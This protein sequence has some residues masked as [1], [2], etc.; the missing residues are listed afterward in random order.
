[1]PIPQLSRN[2]NQRWRQTTH[3]SSK[4]GHWRENNNN[5][6]PLWRRWLRPIILLASS[7]FLLFA[8]Y[9]AY[10]TW[11]LPSP[12]KLMKR[13][14]AES[15]KIYARDCQTLL[16]EI[17]GEQ[18]RT[19]ITLNDIPANVKNA[20]IAIEDKNFYKHGGFSVVAIMRTAIT[21][22][23]FSKKAGGS[24]LTQ[25]FVKNAV[26]SNE[27]TY[28]RK[29]KE[30]LLSYRL[31][32]NFSKDQ[33]LQMYLNEIP[34]GSNAYGV[35]AASQFYFGKR[36]K[37]TNL[38]EAAILAALPQG[39]SRYSPY[40]AN[41]DLLITRQ[42]YILDLMVEQD[43]IS[44]EE[45]DA[46]KQTPIAFQK[47]IENITAPHFVMYIKEVLAEKYGEKTAEQ[48]G[49][50]VCT[51]LDAEK[52]KA[53]ETAVTAYG[54]RNAKQYN[55]SNA[56]LVSMDPKTGEVLAMVGSRDYFNEEIDGQV[57]VALKP[58]QPGSSFKPIA[59]TAAFI[60]GFYPET[61]V[62]D[63][64]TNFST[65][66]ANPYEPQN[67]SGQYYG[68]VS[69]RQA[70]AGSLNIPAVKA[71]YLAGL[72]NVISLA[73]TMGY[74]SLGDKNRYG[75]TLVLGGGEV[76]LLEHVNAYAALAREGELPTTIFIRKI[77]DAKGNVLEEFKTPTITKVIEPNFVRMT[78][79]ILSDNAA[80]AYVFG[81][82]NYLNLGA[83][84][85]AAKTGT[86]NDYRDAWTIGYTPSLVTGVW[87]GNNDNS[88]M[89]IGSDGSVVAA[90]IW[91]N[92][93]KA[94]L[95]NSP[96]ENFNT[97]TI[98][99]DTRGILL[100]QGFAEKII[101]IDSA[102]GLLATD[103]TPPEMVIEKTY[104]QTHNIL[105][106]V[107]K[108]N[109]N[110]NTPTNPENDPQFSSWENGV[111][112]WITSKQAKD[113]NFVVTQPP[114]ESDTE[115]KPE[116]KPLFSVFGL[117]QNQIITSEYLSVAL[118]ASAPRG[119]KLAEYYID[120]QLFSASNELP[121]ALTRSLKIL[122]NGDKKMTIKV[123]DDIYNCSSVDYTFTLNIP[124]T[125]QNYKFAISLATPADKSNFSEK[126]LPLAIKLNSLSPENIAIIKLYTLKDNQPVE[127]AT[128]KIV[129]SDIETLFWNFS[130]AFPAG[131]YTIWAEAT[132]W[133]NEKIVTKKIEINYLPSKVE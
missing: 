128:K 78:N 66:P 52:Q 111:A 47:R 85:V 94:A 61:S 42:K 122:P 55:A 97:Y 109:P 5:Q 96:I 107:D 64:P 115:H 46:A 37:D 88:K 59:Y 125:G 16:Y 72:D 84:P 104:A 21:N 129:R 56:A 110:N 1:M 45:A 30:L 62:Y 35:E 106:F 102:S 53:A 123:C 18:K 13:Q 133:N 114:T 57:N 83:R 50:N 74:T 86:T 90:P 73:K 60:K 116:N 12:D 19:L 89:K 130:P 48:G 2:N 79:S 121:F 81:A 49:F 15:T 58:R 117:T 27:K 7:F 132:G 10:L 69:F 131:T 63:A 28:T 51:T 98:A 100:G 4:S 40:G 77:K 71:L 6:Q 126:D 31:E 127:I 92:Y 17:H 91:N 14:V 80:R 9:I 36:A 33:I 3:H 38:A 11:T 24:T 93:M 113:H 70:L 43:Y 20:T 22:L 67:Y 44:Q 29:I 65:D 120:G 87:V 119:V 25:Q 41:K 68:P 108:D 76:T 118:T 95:G 82:Q 34:Y 105:Y 124:N 39:P 26:L 101:K 103:N 99:P 54:D 32:Q 8:I 75:L 112:K 23:L